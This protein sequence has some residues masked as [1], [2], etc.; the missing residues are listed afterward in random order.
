MVQNPEDPNKAFGEISVPAKAKTVFM[1]SRRD[2][3]TSARAGV[4]SINGHNINTPILW[5]GHNFKGP[6]NVWEER[7]VRMPGVLVNACE[8]MKLPNLDQS[9]YEPG[10]HSYLNFTG[11][12]MMDSGG[13]LFQKHKR[14]GISASSIA[15]IYKEARIDIGVALDHPLDP[16]LPTHKN[17]IRWHRTLRNIE[18]MAISASSYEFMP[19]V[20][21]YTLNALMVACKELKSLLGDPSLVGVGSLVPLIKNSY[22]GNGFRYDRSNGHRG[23]NITFI[24]DAIKLVRDEF[25]HSFLHVFGVGGIT[26]ALSIF[27]LGADSVDSVAWRLKA[28]YGAIQLPGV[29][30][31]FLSPRPNSQ[32]VRRVIDGDE[33]ILLAACRCPVCS[34]YKG[35]GWRKRR[36]DNSFKSRSMHNG[37][38]FLEEV[39][40]FR[41]AI[42]KGRGYNFIAKGLTKSH[43]LFSLLGAGDR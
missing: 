26:T 32:K 22:L 39:H 34:V 4:L 40:S 8:V 12:V 15:E 37:W 43:R 1:E 5:L 27:A 9:V 3:C 11:P 24:A 25:P 35:I 20:H 41:S 31:R 13:Y 23:D 17:K 14:L 19:V 2:K 18:L 21:G 30:D 36:L 29:S 6:L 10:M 42:L 38:V 28:A 33:E 7:R 16:S